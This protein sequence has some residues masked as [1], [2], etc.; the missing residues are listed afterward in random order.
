MIAFFK[1]LWGLIQPYSLRFYLGLTMG[2]LAGVMEPIMIF[3]VTLVYRLLFPSSD[4]PSFAAKLEWAPPMIRDWLN[5]LPTTGIH[6]QPRAVLLIVSLIPLVLLL[7][8]TFTYLNNYFLQWAS[9]R[10]VMDLN[11]KLFTHIIH[12]PVSFFNKTSS[13]Q[14]MSRILND[15]QLLQNVLSHSVAVLIKDPVTLFGLI[16]FLLWTQPKLTLISLVALPLCFAPVIAFSRKVRRAS[17]SLQERAA[18]MTVV[19]A[20]SFTSVRVLKAY[21]LEARVARH[22]REV[23]SQA[24][25]F[26]MRMVRASEFPGPLLEFI[27]SI[28]VALV[29]VYLAIH[30]QSDHKAADFLGI[31]LTMFSIYRPLK[32]LTRLNSNL[33]QARAAS[34][35]VFELLD[36]KSDILEPASPKNMD[37]SSASIEFKNVSFAFGEKTVLNE[38]N[39]VVRPGQLIALVGGSGSGKTTLTNLLLRFYDPTFGA[40][41]INGLNLRD[42]LTSNLRNQI[43]VVTQET[44]L[45]NDSIGNNIELGRPGASMAEIEQAARQANAHDFIMEK[46]AG[47]GTM[48]GEK[49]SAL[50]GGQRQRIAIARAILKQAP[51]LILDEATNALDTASEH[52]VQEA[53][54]G[55][56]QGRTC[57]C[58]A[59][60]LS[61]IQ[62]AD[63]IVVM[64]QGQI[65]ETGKHE[66]LLRQGGVYS[67]LYQLQFRTQV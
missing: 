32:N 65:V 55:L 18:E 49:G 24:V 15:T 36:T 34:A 37:A 57:I 7:R 42:V 39:L 46:A 13:G 3:T 31:V 11:V 35:R 63:L 40:I 12:L 26:I 56:M 47:Y 22:F 6:H 44:I 1:K 9:V 58:I 14:L 66:E 8:G 33:Q 2:V 16:G 23:T 30:V 53:L 21:N 41:E 48:V 51:I 61:S 25:S 27:G 5:Y 60:R 62:H 45:F 17:G 52:A 20:E 28:G 67:K 54:A 50:S 43:A 29:L 19:M 38:I 64:D 10:A 4:S 59:H